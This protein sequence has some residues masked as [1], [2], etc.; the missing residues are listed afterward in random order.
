MGNPRVLV[1]VP[2]RLASTRLPRKLL[3]DESGR[4]LLAHTLD[5][6]L[7]ARTPGAVVAAVDHEDLL[8]AAVEAGAEGV[9]TDPDLPSGTD[10]M[11][12]AAQSFPEAEFLVNVQ[13]DEAEIEAEAIDAVCNALLEGADAVT[14]CA[15]LPAQAFDDAAAVKV[16]RDLDGHAL[17]FSRA[18]IPY[19]RLD[20]VDGPAAPAAPRLHIG[21]YG[22]RREV[23]RDFASWQPTPLERRESL[24]QLRLLEHGVRLR[25]IDWPR[26]FAG[27][28][29]RSDYDAFLKRWRTP[30]SSQS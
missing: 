11:W 26:A 6:C 22:F 18:P 12:A 2:A 7:A 19:P 14:L 3:L 17:Y 1:V 13:G 15:P 10:R 4:P 28:D 23:L 29:T 5:R 25:V 24:E 27:I 30:D 9:S 8:T 16:V 20:S 21:V